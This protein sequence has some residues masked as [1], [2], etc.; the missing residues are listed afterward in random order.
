V[1]CH[2]AHESLPASDP[3][4]LTHRANRDRA[5]ARCHS[6]PA[7][8]A[9][10][11]TDVMSLW[12]AS[13]HGGRAGSGVQTPGCTGCHGVHGAAPPAAG[14]VGKVCGQ[15][16]AAERRYLEAGGHARTD[17][18][19][20]SPEC[21][22]CHGTHAIRSQS[23]DSLATACVRCHRSGTREE[24]LGRSLRDELRTAAHAIDQAAV[25]VAQADAIPV[26]TEDYH[27]RLDDARRSLA[28]ARPAVHA[29]ALAPVHEAAQQAR[30]TGEE[31]SDSVRRKLGLVAERW[32]MLGVYWLFGILLL[33]VLD[34][35]RR[36]GPPG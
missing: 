6:T 32:L 35:W 15:C 21:A 30:A 33:V 34:R 5:C 16:H 31:V 4:S 8:G 14:D 25:L 17:T 36:R 22:G 26:P 3:R 19:A 28:Q 10:A 27:A 18:H 9:A 29:V 2:G 23:P 12:R 20:D 11:G 24:A 1:D 7:A 13:V